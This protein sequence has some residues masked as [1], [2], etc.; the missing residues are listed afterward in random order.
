M[1]VGLCIR[2]AVLHLGKWPQWKTFQK[3]VY[4]ASFTKCCTSYLGIRP[5]RSLHTWQAS[6]DSE[7][8]QWQKSSVQYKDLAA[9]FKKRLDKIH[10][11]T[12]KPE[13]EMITHED[14][15]YF[16]E[17]NCVYRF[18]KTIG[19][20]S[21][22]MLFSPEDAGLHDSLIQCIRVSPQQTFVAVG[23]KGFNCEDS[24]CYVV[25]LESAPKIVHKISN[26]FRFEW[27][28]DRVL[29]HTKLENLQCRSVFLT[30]FSDERT[31]KL[32][33]MEQDPR[34]FVDLYLTR[35][36]SFLTINSNSKT[37]SEVWLVD[38][39]CPL[40]PPVLV[41]QRVPGMI[42]H[43][44]HSNGYLYILTTQ[45]EPAEYKLM[46]ASVKSSINQWK[47]IYHVKPH[48]RL[49]DMEIIKDH[50]VM[51]LKKHNELH[52]DV[53]L[54]SSELLCHSLKDGTLVPVTIF[55]K[56]GDK[57]TQRPL[58]V[59]VYG[60][61]G[62]D[63]NMNFKAENKLLVEDGWILAYCHVRG[64]GELGC[65]WH[66]QGILNRKP[67]GF[68]DLKACIKHIHQLGFSQPCY[69]AIMAASAG[70]V[71]AGA[72]ANCDPGLFKAMILEAPFL[73]VLNTMMDSSLPLTLEEE[74]EWG[75]P[76][77]NQEH[78]RSIKSYCPYQNIRPQI[79]PSVLITAYENDQRIPLKGLV[80]YIEKLRTAAKQYLQTSGLPDSRMPNILLDVYP[81]GSHCDSLPWE[82]S[83]QKVSM[84]LSFLYKELNLNK[85]NLQR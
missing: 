6:L 80:R 40:Q 50:C 30:D 76:A 60:A 13:L 2:A 28:N 84:H 82:E 5:Y 37:T 29:F 8:K 53:T 54:L 18:Q 21:L 39:N 66:K 9:F 15:V 64:G 35:D 51:L 24:E 38:C 65:S 10:L 23:L 72:L 67:N 74:E 85:S 83:L 41:Q 77:C 45:G 33:Y 16:E 59:H 42:Y 36:H 44:E 61:Y 47:P 56:G 11:A 58:L 14:Y 55:Y 27:V 69:T 63:L 1:K 73:D 3:Q 32:V 43:V 79:Y 20:D 57:L 52:M 12:A 49:V 31:T 25:N 81:G 62:M 68:H 34:F 70:G 19:E 46:K 75:S 4:L 78:Y 7:K 17:A 71:V 48:S 22:E 26:I